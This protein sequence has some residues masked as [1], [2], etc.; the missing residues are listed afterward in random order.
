MWCEGGGRVAKRVIVRTKW[1]AVEEKHLELC[2][3]QTASEV[4]A[5]IVIIAPISIIIAMQYTHIAYVLSI[6]LLTYE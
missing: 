5:I 3:A 6:L 2:L 4:L 1:T